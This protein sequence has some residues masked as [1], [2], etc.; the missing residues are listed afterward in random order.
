MFAVSTRRRAL[1][2]ATGAMIAG[3]MVMGAGSAQASGGPACGAWTDIGPNLSARTCVDV[4]A[5]SLELWTDIQ[6]STD[7]NQFVHVKQDS[8]NPQNQVGECYLVV[9]PGTQ[10]LCGRFYGHRDAGFAQAVA[11]VE[12]NYDHRM[13]VSPSVGT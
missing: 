5:S 6:N 8:D 3:G 7:G 1:A 12:S 11:W 4:H 10:G 2:V 9:A 13:V